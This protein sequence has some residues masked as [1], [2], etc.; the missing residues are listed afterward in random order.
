M[1]PKL[2]KVLGKTLSSFKKGMEEDLGTEESDAPADKKK[3]EKESG[4]EAGAE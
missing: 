4:H 1:V 3:A 2:S